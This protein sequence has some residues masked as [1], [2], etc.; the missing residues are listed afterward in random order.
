ME[1]EIPEINQE[2]EQTIQ[3]FINVL[4]E[5]VKRRVADVPYLK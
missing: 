2:M 3:N 4:G 1:T 5:A